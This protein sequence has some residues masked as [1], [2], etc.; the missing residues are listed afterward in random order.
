MRARSCKP[1][2]IE[3]VALTRLIECER[4]ERK[5]WLAIDAVKAVLAPGLHR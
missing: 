1:A 5:C 2:G 4:F 3:A